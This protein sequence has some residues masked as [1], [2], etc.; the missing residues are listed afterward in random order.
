MAGMHGRPKNDARKTERFYVD[1]DC[2]AVQAGVE[3]PGSVRNI[4]GGGAMVKLDPVATAA[5]NEK[6]IELIVDGFGPLPSR[7]MWRSAFRFGVSFNISESH[8]SLVEAR[9]RK[10]SDPPKTS[11]KAAVVDEHAERP[12]ENGAATPTPDAA[13]VI[14]LPVGSDAERDAKKDPDITFERRT[15]RFKLNIAGTFEQD[16]FNLACNIVDISEGGA[17]L[18]FDSLAAS[19]L[20]DS[21]MVVDIP[22]Y[23]RLPG[24][25]RWRRGNQCGVAFRLTGRQAEGLAHRLVKLRQTAESA[26]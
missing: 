18:R 16:G 25:F 12:V 8:R 4:S 7:I 21:R 1:L 5:L 20:R 17:R 19:A 13:N 22:G 6:P 11:K 10:L 23:G 24:D 3:I 15:P 26:N 2:R 14:A 9:I